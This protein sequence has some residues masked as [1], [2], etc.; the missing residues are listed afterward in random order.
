MK[1]A[2]IK[3]GDKVTLSAENGLGS[4]PFLVLRVVPGDVIHNLYVQGLNGETWWARIQGA[5]VC[6]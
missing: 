6:A 4:N 5:K 3:A 1:N 2:H